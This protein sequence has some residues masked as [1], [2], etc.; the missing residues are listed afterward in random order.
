MEK[1]HS[2]FAYSYNRSGVIVYGIDKGGYSV[3]QLFVMYDSLA[4]IKR[5][6]KSHG[7]RGVSHMRKYA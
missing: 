7:V 4:D 3:H 6:L 1:F 2:V 5:E